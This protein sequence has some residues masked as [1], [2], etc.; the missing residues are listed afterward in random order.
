MCEK[1]FALFACLELADSQLIVS[2]EDVRAASRIVAKKNR[3]DKLDFA[4]EK[5]KVCTETEIG[6]HSKCQ[7]EI[8]CRS[9]DWNARGC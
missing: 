5:K 8:G 4:N 1:S 9:L 2:V 3:V 7:F 6:V